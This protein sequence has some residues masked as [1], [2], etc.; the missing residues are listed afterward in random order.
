MEPVTQGLDLQLQE[1]FLLYRNS[2]GNIY[3]IWFYEKDEC[4]RIDAMLNKLIKDTDE[5]RKPV[6]KITKRSLNMENKQSNNVDIF[7]MLSRA[8]ENFTNKSSANASAELSRSKSMGNNIGEAMHMPLSAPLGPD[9]TSQSVMDFFAKAKVIINSTS[10]ELFKTQSLTIF[11]RR[12]L[13]KHWAFEGWTAK[14]SSCL[15]ARE[16]T[17]AGTSHVSSGSS[18]SREHWEATQVRHA[19]TIFPPSGD[20]FNAEYSW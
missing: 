16:Q 3:G 10:T 13:G 15:C 12:I 20:S 5:N 8:Q 6:N 18:H 17:T 14:R 7:S 2:K 1:P 9:V 4:V 11:L 19:A